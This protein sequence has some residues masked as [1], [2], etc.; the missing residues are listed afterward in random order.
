[1]RLTLRNMLAYMDELLEPAQREEIKQKIDESEFATGIMH[2]VRDVTRRIRLG[3]PKLT[4][5]GMGLDPNT[6]AMYLD[7]TLS[8]ERVPD[9]E[10]VCLESDVH[11][12]E[13]AA[14]HQVLALVLGEPAE[15]DPALRR[16]LYEVVQTNAPAEPAKIPPPLPK[17]ERQVV[18]A[19]RQR[20]HVPEYL[21]KERRSRLWTIAA[22][23]L[24]AIL[25]IGVVIRTLGPFDRSN[26]ALALLL[27]DEAAAPNDT[28]SQTNNNSTTV[29]ELPAKEDAPSKSTTNGDTVL[30]SDGTKA[31]ID[32]KLNNPVQEN[33]KSIPPDGPKLPTGSDAKAPAPPEPVETDATKETAPPTVDPPANDAQGT[34]AQPSA[35]DAAVDEP[36][37]NENPPRT[38][39]APVGRFLTD[40]NVLLRLNRRG[41]W[42]RVS[43][44]DILNA[45][46]QLLVLPTY[47]PTITLTAGLTVQILG[48]TLVELLPADQTGAPG[49][50][51]P[52]GRVVLMTA[53]KPDV[54]VWLSL[55][56]REGI[57]TFVDGESTLA[58][59]VRRYLPA[60]ADPEQERPRLGVD[61]YA[62]SGKIDWKQSENPQPTQIVG[63]QRV[64]LSSYP[65]D[66]TKEDELPTWITAEKLSGYD[67]M[68]T[69]DFNR[70]LGEDNQRPVALTIREFVDH[71]RDE[72]RYLAARSLGLIDEFDPFIDAFNDDYQ[73]AVWPQQIKSLQ[74]ALAR[75][76]ETAAL[77][78]EAF[79]RKRAGD[80][81]ELYRILWGY[82]KADI[83]NGDADQ[84]V[85]YLNHEKLDFR[86]LAFY[87]L[88]A[89][90]GVPAN[91]SLYRPEDEPGQRQPAIRQWRDLIK[92]TNSPLSP[93]GALDHP[94]P[95]PT[96]QTKATPSKSEIDE[97][98]STAEPASSEQ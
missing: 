14:C 44:G 37:I 40:R 5:K 54:S 1:M 83:Q 31:A 82:S 97:S 15:I 45:G 77:V 23:L 75:G 42:Q 2:R 73:K 3:A 87:A 92:R 9:F 48:E 19:T 49:L 53:G 84:L 61:L 22:T 57:A 51:I 56:G 59:E 34:E 76:P 81:K 74:A 70:A 39:A 4:G 80:A 8:S 67:T 88:R 69:N 46:D 64:T 79:E 28:A 66:T 11:L 17:V 96:K 95:V 68:A 10:K 47:R 93:Q 72:L 20:P 58:A 38:N 86:V 43:Q 94:G 55:G 52:Y 63:P 50:R 13:V 32:L 91:F 16:K 60:G 62:S 65:Y 35:A 78:R 30:T 33:G 41:D 26:P 98:A 7:N 90:P 21:R 24:L 85:E 71:R 6:V 36:P 12:A 89:V 25:L 18:A 29:D 27:G